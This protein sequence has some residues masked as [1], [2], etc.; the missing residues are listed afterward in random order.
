MTSKKNKDNAKQSM[1]T[2]F[3]QDKLR[4]AKR[5]VSACVTGLIVICLLVGTIVHAYFSYGNSPLIIGSLAFIC[6]FLCGTGVYQGIRGFRE[7]NKNYIT[8]KWGI[9]LNTTVIIIFILL[10]IRGIS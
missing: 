6:I 8:C 7:R 1:N 5:G 2:K 9:L 4:H 3:G 10:Y